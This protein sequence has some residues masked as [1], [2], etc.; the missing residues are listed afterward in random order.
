[1]RTQSSPSES[2]STRSRVRGRRAIAILGGLVLPLWLGALVCAPLVVHAQP[3]ASQAD[4]AARAAFEEGRTFYDHGRFAD[5]LRKFQ[6]SY[7]LSNNPKL[8]FNIGRAADSEGDH[9]QAVDA[10]TAYLQRVPDAENREFVE[11]RLAKLRGQAAPAGPSPQPDAPLEPYPPAYVSP[12]QPQAYGQPAAQPVA[13]QPPA[14]EPSADMPG[15][16]RLYLGGRLN[17]LGNR[18]LETTEFYGDADLKAGVGGQL[19]FEWVPTRFFGIGAEARLLS[20]K[21]DGGPAT[22]LF[23]LTVKPSARI[24]LRS[25][26]IEFYLALPVGLTVPS[27]DGA[28]LQVGGT[29]G[30]VGGLNWFFTRQF[31]LNLE[32]GVLSH[33]YSFDEFDID[34]T[35]TQFTLLSASFVLAL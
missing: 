20:N 25:R 4:P 11:A 35:E 9:A 33:F 17:V 31:G 18:H 15:R 3:G 7:A 26:P 13:Y 12:G 34:I 24:G 32:L 27:S 28:D 8:L 14:A 21:V 19:G 6:E 10:Y 16:F 2:S 29:V 5:A 1:M 22:R 30:F 23:D